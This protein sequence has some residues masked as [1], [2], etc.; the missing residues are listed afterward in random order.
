MALNEMA[1]APNFIPTWGKQMK[2]GG[3]VVGEIGGGGAS[4]EHQ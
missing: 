2:A 3:G 1:P 4:G